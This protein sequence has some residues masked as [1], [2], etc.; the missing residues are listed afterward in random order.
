MIVIVILTVIICYI[1][2]QFLFTSSNINPN[3]KYIVITKCYTGFGNE[4]AIE[5]DKQRFHVL[6]GTY[7]PNNKDSLAKLLSSRATIFQLYI[8]RQEDIDDTYELISKKTKILH[9]LV[10]NAGIG[11]GGFIDLIIIESMRKMMDV[12]FFG[13][14][15]MT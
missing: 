11:S 5:L 8:N 6:A 3:G 2:Y 15:A 10:N 4:L 13:H 1:I 7:N 9:A 12:N 14:V